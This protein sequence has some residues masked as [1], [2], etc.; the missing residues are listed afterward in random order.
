[1]PASGSPAPGIGRIR[2]P[3]EGVESGLQVKAVPLASLRVAYVHPRPVGRKSSSSCGSRYSRPSG[4]TIPGPPDRAGT[5][6]AR[7]RGR[8]T[9]VGRMGK[10]LTTGHRTCSEAQRNSPSRRMIPG[11]TCS[12]EDPATDLATSR[13]GPMN[14]RLRAHLGALRRE[15]HRSTAG[16]PAVGIHIAHHAALHALVSPGRNTQTTAGLRHLYEHRIYKLTCGE[17]TAKP[18]RGYG[19]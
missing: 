5:D 10:R 8:P 2:A 7:F 11:G 9:Q 18:G 13:A 12:A 16:P 19:G 3:G 14:R 6:T 17:Y 15:T 1:M 4:L